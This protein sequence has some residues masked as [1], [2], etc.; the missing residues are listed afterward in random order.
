MSYGATVAYALLILVI[1]F[2]T[3]YL[4]LTRR[5]VERAT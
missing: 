2:A 1:I 4:L 3:I 5:A